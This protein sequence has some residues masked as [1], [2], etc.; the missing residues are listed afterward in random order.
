MRS[1]Q[2]K[3]EI[4][5]GNSTNLLLSNFRIKRTPQAGQEGGTICPEGAAVEAA[6][7]NAN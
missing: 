4:F 1:F 2:E 7:K 6:E 3:L 5:T